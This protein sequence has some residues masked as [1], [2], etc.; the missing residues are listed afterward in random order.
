MRLSGVIW[1]RNLTMFSNWFSGDECGSIA[2]HRTSSAWTKLEAGCWNCATRMTSSTSIFTNG[3]ASPGTS[4]NAV[5]LCRPQ[6]PT[7]YGNTLLFVHTHRGLAAKTARK[8]HPKVVGIR[9]VLGGRR[10]HRTRPDYAT[11]HS[12]VLREC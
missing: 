11:A 4:R 6:A 8:L 10:H 5:C 1:L 9:R 7:R 3:C 2:L 12:R